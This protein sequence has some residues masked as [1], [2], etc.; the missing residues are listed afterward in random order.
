MG[1]CNHRK[2]CCGQKCFAVWTAE[3]TCDPE[4]PGAWSLVSATPAAVC[5]VSGATGQWIKVGSVATYWV[6]VAE[7][8]SEGGQTCAQL[9]E[10]AALTPPDLPDVGSE[11]CNCGCVVLVG[12]ATI[13]Y[14]INR[15]IAPLAQDIECTVEYPIFALRQLC[16]EPYLVTFYGEPTPGIYM[17]LYQFRLSS[18]WFTNVGIYY[19]VYT[20]RWRYARSVHNA[21]GT[22]SSDVGD[23]SGYLSTGRA[24]YENA[25]WPI[26]QCAY[27]PD[28]S[29][30]SYWY[31]EEEL[32]F[33]GAITLVP[34]CNLVPPVYYEW[35]STYD[36]D[37]AQWGAVQAAGETQ[38]P[39]HDWAGTGATRTKVTAD[40]VPPDSPTE[41]PEISD[42]CG[43]DCYERAWV[44]GAWGSAA[45]VASGV[46]PCPNFGCGGDWEWNGETCRAQLC[47]PYGDPAPA[48]PI[49]TP[50]IEQRGMCGWDCY[51][52][53][54]IG[55]V[56]GGHWSDPVQVE[57]GV[58]SPP[59]VDCVG[60]WAWVPYDCVAMICVPYG[61]PAPTSEPSFTPTGEDLCCRLAHWKMLYYHCADGNLVFDSKETGC[62][63]CPPVPDGYEGTTSGTLGE[64]PSCW[65][66]ARKI[67]TPCDIV[68]LVW[69]GFSPGDPALP[70]PD[71]DPED[72]TDAATIACLADSG[73]ATITNG[74][75]KVG[76]C[77]FDENLTA[78]ITIVITAMDG[79]FPADTYTTNDVPESSCGTWM[80][81]LPDPEGYAI[82]AEYITQRATYSG[83]AWTLTREKHKVI[84]GGGGAHQWVGIGS[85]SKVMTTNSCTG[86][87]HAGGSSV[88]IQLEGDI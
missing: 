41:V 62:S 13:R 63:V 2:C 70:C 7:S 27:P 44:D 23:F 52:R 48:A 46:T 8:C 49:W 59:C 75:C 69:C 53:W 9:V 20:G 15:R 71:L 12:T 6:Q 76:S 37:E 65:S 39:P 67:A 80:T 74:C 73:P 26:G 40:N 31:Y 50:T 51:K 86:G 84:A 85:V 38:T 45:Q 42:V 10:A 60:T 3:F 34:D 57:Y 88:A 68:H 18:T 4:G 79:V 11:A 25:G 64:C 30:S 17:T 5:T 82:D 83:T 29:Q 56:A 66:I 55:D 87:S 72:P 43:W 14:W 58:A 47:V 1:A 16:S 21:N 61:D 35:T 19:D 22:F 33:E 32:I 77:C 54:W 24:T 36:C 78:D 81:P 28:Y